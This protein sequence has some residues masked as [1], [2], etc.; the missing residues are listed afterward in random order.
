MNIN[1][2]K[3]TGVICK[4]QGKYCAEDITVVPVLE[5]KSATP[6]QSA[7]MRLLAQILHQSI[8]ESCLLAS[9][10]LQWILQ[11]KLL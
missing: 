9:L 11:I 1:V 7:A 6:T 4:T 2:T 10:I 3:P 5:E 8:R